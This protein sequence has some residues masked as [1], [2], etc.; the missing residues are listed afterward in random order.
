MHAWGVRPQCIECVS[1][2]NAAAIGKMP[3]MFS[4]ILH[5]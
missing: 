5:N 3:C 1:T 4:T 2:I